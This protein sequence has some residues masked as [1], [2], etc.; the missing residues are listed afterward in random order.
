MTT[1]FADISPETALHLLAQE[2]G[3]Q[4]Q[5]WD[6]S[7][8]LHTTPDDTKRAILTA[9]G[10]AVDTDA[11]A[12][13]SL[14]H[15]RERP[16]TRLAPPVL[17]IRRTTNM[18]PI[19]I[20]VSIRD[21]LQFSHLRWNLDIEGGSTPQ[22]GEIPAREL[23]LIDVADVQGET[24]SRRRL[25]LA[26]DLPDGYH[27]L[28]VQFAGQTATTRIIVTPAQAYIPPW[29]ENGERQWGLSCQTYA[30][31]KDT[32]WG[33]GDFSALADYMQS[34]Q[35]LGACIVGINP[36]HAL[37][38][39][40]PDACSP[41]SPSSRS[42]LN[43]LMIAFD[44]IPFA[45]DC[46][47]YQKLVS[48]KEFQTKLS[49]AHKKPEVDYPAVM[50]LKI[51]AL[52]AL[53]ADFRNKPNTAEHEAFEAFCENEGL[54][55]RRFAQFCALHEILG[56]LPWHAWPA[57]FRNPASIPVEG[58]T[59]A[60]IELVTF[61]AFLQ[62]L[63][64]EQ[65][66]RLK[67]YAPDIG[68]YR[69][70][71]IGGNADGADVWAQQDSVAKG[72]SFGA[73]PDAFSAVGQDWGL[74]PSHPHVMHDTAYSAFIH[75]VR[76]NMANAAALRI[77]HVMGLLRLFWIPNGKPA[78]EGA[79][80]SYP[81]DDLLGIL[82]LESHRNHCFLIGEDLGTVPDDF[83][84]RMANER[85]LS[86]RVTYFERWES[87]LF[88]RPDT[89]PPL[90]LA[91]PTTHDMPSIAGH[92]AGTDIHLRQSIG[93]FGTDEDMEQAILA[94]E[95]ERIA[96]IAALEDQN[97]LPDPMPSDD[98]SSLSGL[99]H[100]VLGYSARSLSCLLMVNPGDL[101]MDMNQINLPGTVD[102]H[103]N[104]RQRMSIAAC[105]IATNP[106]IRKG[107]EAVTQE[108]DSL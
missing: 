97:L 23:P 105:D 44:W 88:K 89:Y 37:F 78:L 103:P 95:Q 12:I 9:M 48:S 91:T 59:T 10:F 41:Y 42:F 2:T 62:W 50:D 58:F 22:H 6:I 5:Y 27:T 18:P 86:Y 11:D 80:V 101:L 82:A 45:K 69:D 8:T 13:N 68:L 14:K 32:D 30:L 15:W 73:P 52:R 16:W 74:P 43:P 21:T 25:S 24:I 63:C 3:V 47:E 29:M 20:L 61:H 46:L 7:G 19:S 108:R 28:T 49:S 4:D 36:I 71:A 94:R 35:S 34:A 106:M 75:M 72:V 26:D 33:I 39:P 102:E 67:H 83:R 31:R 87:G 76:A 84:D 64:A 38:Q 93:T 56:G 57:Q 79:Y 98:P 100:A 81:F 90:A 53:F 104:W 92:W 107:I 96:L 99:T 70:L 60:N 65:L 40:W 54:P 85:L 77:D 66:Q 17:V 1:L 51:K 55:L